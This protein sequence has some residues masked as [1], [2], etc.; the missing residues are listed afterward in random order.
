LRVVYSVRGPPHSARFSLFD[1]D[2]QP[3]RLRATRLFNSGC[4]ISAGISTRHRHAWRFPYLLSKAC[5]QTL[6]A[7]I[8]FANIN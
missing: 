2:V 7:D 4:D 1:Q 5:R 6:C 3:R 8:R